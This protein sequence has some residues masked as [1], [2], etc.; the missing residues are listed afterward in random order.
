M[1]GTPTI[2]LMCI[3]PLR[4]NLIYVLF[5]KTH[6]RGEAPKDTNNRN[7][8]HMRKFED[9]KSLTMV[10]LCELVVTRADSSTSENQS[11]TYTLRERMIQLTQSNLD[12]CRCPPSSILTE[13]S[14]IATWEACFDWWTAIATYRHKQSILEIC[15]NLPMQ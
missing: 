2:L 7:Q 11:S 5:S 8:L 9:V 12:I 4:Q 1:A 13:A 3:H 15:K 10:V 6:N 14:C